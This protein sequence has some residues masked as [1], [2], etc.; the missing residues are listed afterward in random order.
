[1]PLAVRVSHV[2]TWTVLLE[3]DGDWILLGD[4]PTRREALEDARLELQLL[5][6]QL[7]RRLEA[8]E[9]ER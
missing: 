5:D 6:A 1:M 7:A 9:P 4:G 3:K 8:E 2:G